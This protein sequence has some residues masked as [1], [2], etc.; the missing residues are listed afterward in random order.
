MSTKLTKEELKK[1]SWMQRETNT[2]LSETYR[3]AIINLSSHIE[4]L[5]GE[6]EGLKFCL[7]STEEHC[8]EL[9]LKTPCVCCVEMP[10]CYRK[11]CECKS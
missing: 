3:K 8:N 4:A 7:K 9:E 5:E 11:D 2:Y 6:V 1:I 10:E